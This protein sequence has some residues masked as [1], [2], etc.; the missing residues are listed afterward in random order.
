MF[1]NMQ[2]KQEFFEF[3][4]GVITFLIVLFLPSFFD[5]EQAKAGRVVGEN[6]EEALVPSGG[7]TQGVDRD[8]YFG[9]KILHHPLIH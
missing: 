4:I 6:R 3:L 2:K 9:Q 7:H 8:V 1:R 5:L